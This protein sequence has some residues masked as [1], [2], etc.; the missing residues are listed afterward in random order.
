M[1]SDQVSA[2]VSPL[3]LKSILE[4]G[5]SGVVLVDVRENVEFEDWSIEGSVNI[6]LSKID[7]V[8]RVRDCAAGRNVLTICTQ[9]TRSM[10]AIKTLR[11][12][13]I[14]VSS[15]SGRLVAWGKVYNRSAV[16]LVD[17]ETPRPQIRRV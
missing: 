16:S 10:F 17:Y 14:E 5:H 6:P 15:L 12:E 11:E 4:G 3:Q 7:F 1:N 8:Q 2:E 13:G 9:G